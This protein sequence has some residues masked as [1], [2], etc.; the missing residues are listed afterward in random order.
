MQTIN[1]NSNLTLLNDIYVTM[2][3]EVVITDKIVVVGQFLLIR[4]Y[5]NESEPLH[6][7]VTYSLSQCLSN[8]T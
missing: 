1:S 7:T 4:C 8:S 5:R 3:R 6:F 2:S